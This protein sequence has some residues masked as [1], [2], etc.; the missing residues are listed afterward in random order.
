MFVNDNILNAKTKYIAHACNCISTTSAGLA[1]DIFNKYPYANIYTNR[2]S[3]DEPGTIKICG[4]GINDRFVVNL[5]SQIYPGKPKY[6]ESK[7]GYA[8]REKYFHK[9]LLSLAKVENLESV[10]FNYYIGC[11]LAGGDW[12]YYHGTIL[13]FAKFIK[14]KQNADTLI[15][16][17]ENEQV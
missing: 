3:Q 10:A 4:D 16:R 17:I 12:K 8:A 15:Y 14:E 11:G 2:T 7:D 13:N 1:K 5:F 6:P 9:C